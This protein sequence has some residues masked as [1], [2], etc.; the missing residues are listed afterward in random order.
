MSGVVRAC[1]REGG[2]M[3]KCV[4]AC[5]CVNVGGCVVQAAAR[6]QRRTHKKGGGTCGEGGRQWA[7]ESKSCKLSSTVEGMNW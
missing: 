6:G 5:E 4:N 1:E 7:C 3:F 2:C